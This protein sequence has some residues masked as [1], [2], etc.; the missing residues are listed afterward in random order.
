[1]ALL[2]LSPSIPEVLKTLA[3]EWATKPLQPTSTE[4]HLA[5]HPACW[6]SLTSPAYLES[7]LSKA[8]SSHWTVSSSISACLVDSDMR[9]MSG[10]RV[11]TAMWLWNFSCRSRSTISCQSLA[12]FRMPADV[13]LAVI[14]CSP[15][16]TKAMVL[17]KG[18]DCFAHTSPALMASAI[19]LRTW[20]CLNGT[21]TLQVPWSS[22]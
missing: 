10:R 18:Q 12:E 4:R 11:V 5:L 2:F 8:S 19:V 22:C 7:F 20:S 13:L 3:K 6:Q 16:L 14:A 1:M 9:T 17:L 15:A 21:F